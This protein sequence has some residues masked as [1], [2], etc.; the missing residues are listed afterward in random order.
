[1]HKIAAFMRERPLEIVSVDLSYNHIGVRGV[2]ILAEEFFHD[3]NNLRHINLMQCDIKSAGI[4]WLATSECLKLESCRI[5]GNP[6]GPEAAQWICHLIQECPTLVHLDIAETDQILESI[7]CILIVCERSTLKYLDISKII[8]LHHYTKYDP[9]ILAD[10]LAVVLKLN[11][12]LLELHMQKCCF[13]GHDV[14]LIVSGLAINKYLQV[15]DL[16]YNKMGDLGIQSI[17]SWL[18]TRPVLRALIVPGNYIKEFGARAL[19]FG[20][21]FSR[22][23]YLDMTDNK[24]ND[25]GLTFLL[26]S[27]KKSTQM[28]LFFIWGNTVGPTSCKRIERMLESGVFD[29]EY[30]DIKLYTVDGQLYP[31][32]YPSKHYKHKYYCV[33]DYGC[34]VELKIKRNKL[35][36]P[37]A[38][39]RGLINMAHVA[40][41]PPIDDSLGLKV[42]KEP[43]CEDEDAPKNENG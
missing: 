16:G 27:I 4:K 26:D 31:A 3:D 2:Q 34:A 15:L 19:H 39:P 20:L 35:P 41:Y 17:A 22:V 42:R 12:T 14:D 40:R 10:N 13:D 24:I 11:E 43:I 28:R 9:S 29:Q 33:M 25:V 37:D 23:R 21:P 7:E 1:M 30:I 36:H 18:K 8:P 5:N 32:Y 38:L 6:L